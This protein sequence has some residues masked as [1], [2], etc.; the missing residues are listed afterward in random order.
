M[1]PKKTAVWSIV[2]II[3]LLVALLASVGY[4]YVWPTYFK[5]QSAP[6]Q[7]SANTDQNK[8]DQ[9]KDNEVKNAVT[10]PGVNWIK[11]EKLA[12]L[13]LIKLGGDGWIYEVKGYYKVATL[14]NGGELILAT[15]QPEGPSAPELLRFK[16]DSDG[17]YTYLV[18]NS[19]VKDFKQYSA[20]LADEVVE[21]P[22]LS[23][24]SLTPPNL[25]N[26]AKTNFKLISGSTGLFSDL[27]KT[28]EIGKTEY[29]TFYENDT[30]S[31]NEVV[32]STVNYALKLNDSSYQTYIINFPFLTDDELAQITWSDGI[33]NT[34]KYTA[35]GYISCGLSA[36]NSLVKDISQ[37]KDRAKF[38]GKTKQGDSVY[39]LDSTD[40]IM[41]RAYENYKVGRTENIKSLA[42]IT[43]AR[44]VFLWQAGTGDYVIFT[45]RDYGALA[46]CGK[47][48]IY[49]YPEKPTEVS[50]KVGANITKSEP[51]YS[52]GWN[53]LA[54]PDGKL[55]VNGQA[56]PNLFWEGQGDGL[57][58]SVNDGYVVKQED[59]TNTLKNH[60]TKLGLNSQES[61]DFL[62]FWLPK[63]PE[64]PY[65]RLTWFGTKQ[66]NELAPLTVVPQPDTTIRIFLDFEG[67]NTPINLKSQNLTAPARKGFTLVEWGGL[68][69][70]E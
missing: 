14:E 19:S 1:E 16:K 43:A 29:G 27:A 68:L 53:T 24:N 52:D 44:A 23:Y 21:N 45:G 54:Y 55:V 28:K 8:T 3:V 13:N 2:V 6:S 69:K 32:L 48:V 33:E 59:L 61:A 66:M 63:M 67:L 18:K 42:E 7:T 38:A 5:K 51:L 36:V 31:E 12:D 41:S 40:A 11:P 34:S 39:T 37:I 47:P 57:Y 10:D 56:Y 20:F 46:E 22:T 64:T 50:V 35:E 60:L 26:L 17:K 62:A 30:T 70:G 65:V 4:F 15:A 58:T 49:L 9:N 25:V